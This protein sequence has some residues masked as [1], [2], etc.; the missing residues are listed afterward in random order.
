MTWLPQWT[1]VFDAIKDIV[2]LSVGAAVLLGLPFA[3]WRL[4]RELHSTARKQAEDNERKAA[5]AH[6]QRLEDLRLDEVRQ[7]GHRCIEVL[8]TIVLLCAPTRVES[9]DDAEKIKSLGIEASLLT[10][11]GRS[12]FFNVPSD[13]WGNEKPTAYRGLRPLILDYVLT[14]FEISDRWPKASDTERMKL[15]RAAIMIEQ[16]FVSLLQKETGRSGT[17]TPETAAPGSGNLLD[18]LIKQ[19]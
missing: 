18:R 19:L 14:G 7:W 3:W 10:E 5:D 11:L 8:Q 2:D 16:N 4:R 17:R 6:R 15:H 13:H 12:Y 1:T 9:P